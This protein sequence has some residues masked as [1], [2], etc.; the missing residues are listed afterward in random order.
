MAEL[1]GDFCYQD[2]LLLNRDLTPSASYE[3]AVDHYQNYGF[4]ENRRYKYDKKEDR[5]KINILIVVVSC[6]KHKHLW[7]PIKKR[8]TNPLIIITGTN[9]NN[10]HFYDKDHQILHLNCNDLYDGLPEKI[11]CMIDEVLHNDHFRDITHILKID[12]HDTYFTHQ[13][14]QNL[15]KYHKIYLFDYLGQKLNCW[16]EDTKGT[17]HF[18]KV[19]INSYWHNREANIS[20]VQYFDGGCSYILSRKAMILINQKYNSCNINLLRVNEIYED[21]MIGRLLKEHGILPCQVN[22][23][24]IGD[25]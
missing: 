17:Y 11:I 7:N 9:N 3:E 18:G 14:I 8:T 19:P 13:N 22:Y 2:Y 23:G 4:Y 25:K 6:H 21:V 20:N 15:Y 16:G 12:D 1:P 10:N 24:I 5:P